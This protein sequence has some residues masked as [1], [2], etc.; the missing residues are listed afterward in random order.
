MW[1][2]SLGKTLQEIGMAEYFTNKY[3]DDENSYFQKGFYNERK[4]L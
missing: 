3:E 4:N 2:E 1:H